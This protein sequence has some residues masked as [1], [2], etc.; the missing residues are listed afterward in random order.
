MER[1]R[2]PVVWDRLAPYRSAERPQ[3]RRHWRPSAEIGGGEMSC[4]ACSKG[5]PISAEPAKSGN[6]E[7]GLSAASA[8]A[9]SKR[10]GTSATGT[11]MLLSGFTLSRPNP[12]RARPQYRRGVAVVDFGKSTWYVHT[13]NRTLAKPGSHSN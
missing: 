13:V 12:F 1:S 6:G 7:T 3:A 9:A 2:A 5:L 10:D 8:G 4:D 11:R